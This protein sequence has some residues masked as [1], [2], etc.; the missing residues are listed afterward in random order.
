MEII[1]LTPQGYCGGVKRA[2]S[3][4]IEVNNNPKTKRPIYMLGNIIHNKNVIKSLNDL[5]IISIDGKKTRLELLDKIKSGTVVISAHG[6]SP[7]VI[8]KAKNKGLDIIDAT[9]PNV[10]VVHNNIKKYLELNYTI[11]YIGTKGHPEAEGVLGIDDRIIL[12]SDVDDLENINI[13]GNIFVTNQTTLSLYD[14]KEIFKIIKDKYPNAIID[15]KICNA[16]TLR[17]KAVMNQKAQLCIVVGD[18]SSSNSKKLQLVSEKYANVK[19]YLVED[20]ND[21]NKDWFKN[22]NTVSITS[23]ASTPDDVTQN[24]INKIKEYNI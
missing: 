24:V 9:C 13:S 14:I 23:G 22:I 12:I 19:S 8:L 10:Y 7:E 16:T 5:G 3:M 11:L 2:L 18:T 17:Q 15:D 21:L 20:E 1:K 6:V 4:I